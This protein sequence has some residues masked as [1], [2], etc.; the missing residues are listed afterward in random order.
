VRGVFAAFGPAAQAAGSALLAALAVAA[1]VAYANATS[2]ARPAAL[3]PQSDGTYVYG[4]ERLGP[5]WGY[6]AGWGFVVG[7]IASCAAMALTVGYYGAPEY[8]NLIAA[9][10]VAALTALN[11]TGVQKSATL[12]RVIV[13]FVL[14]VLA[15]VVAE[16]LVGGNPDTAGLFSAPGR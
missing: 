11:Y 15:V 7:K 14:T 9:R 10:S 2:S 8:A 3:Y 16:A 5:F 13:M 6:L 1:V 4:R 12:T